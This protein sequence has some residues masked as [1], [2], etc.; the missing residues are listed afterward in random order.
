[1]LNIQKLFDIFYHQSLFARLFHT[2]VFCLQKEL[3]NC[4]NVLDIGCGPSSPL[5]Y[6]QGIKDK[7]GV[8]PFK[9][10]VLQS[11]KMGI[12]SKYI[13]KKI[14]EVNFPQKS[15]DAVIMIEI[16]EHLSKNDGFKT[17]GKVEKWAR[18]KIIITTPNGFFKQKENKNPLQKH[19]SG[20]TAEEM[21]KM[22]YKVYGL[23]GLK[24]LRKTPEGEQEYPNSGNLMTLIKYR[25]KVFWFLI[26]AFSQIFTYFAPSFAFELFCVKTIDNRS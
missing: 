24:A 26:A 5:Q 6:C 14:E 12:H 18:K 9:E 17:L 25:P 1:M 7:I 3:R 4:Q 20:W 11:K 16:L 22:G 2:T 19:L 8:E 23:S 15:V 10:Y 21:K 13:N